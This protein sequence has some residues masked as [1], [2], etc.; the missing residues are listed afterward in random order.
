MP[1]SIVWLA[2]DQLNDNKLLA[3]ELKADFNG[4]SRR[5]VIKKIGLAAVVALPL[6]S[7]L[8]A[9]TAVFAQACSTGTVDFTC[10]GG[11]CPAGTACICNNP[12]GAGTCGGPGRG[13]MVGGV[14]CT[15]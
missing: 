5:E 11:T 4:Q 1:E 15:S 2:I 3:A 10:V 12:A 14:T 13:C 6:V 9:P 8:V 7:S